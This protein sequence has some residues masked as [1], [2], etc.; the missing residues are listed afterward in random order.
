MILNFM[1]CFSYNSIIISLPCCSDAYV[2][3]DHGFLNSS[4]H[5]LVFNH[6]QL[7]H[8]VKLNINE[9]EKD[10]LSLT[11]ISVR[12]NL[13]VD[14]VKL[15]LGRRTSCKFIKKKSVLFTLLPRW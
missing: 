11:S 3:N 6:H 12:R 9:K 15:F 7:C 13:C 4:N 5:T 8:L 2:A 14:T 10:P 1:S